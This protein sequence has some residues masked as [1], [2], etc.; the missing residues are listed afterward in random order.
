M[1]DP[2]VELAVFEELGQGHGMVGRREHDDAPEPG[3][4]ALAQGVADDDVAQRV[5]D[6]VVAGGAHVLLE[7]GREG[8][9]EFVE[10]G[11]FLAVGEV[12]RLVAGALEALG[13]D[14]HRGA[15]AAHA[16]QEDDGLPLLGRSW[17]GAGAEHER[18]EEDVG[19]C[20][21]GTSRVP[22]RQIVSLQSA[23]GKP[24]IP[25]NREIV[26]TRYQKVKR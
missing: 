26:K 5:G 22:P 12:Q 11:A 14:G 8:I 25:P 7:E 23:L 6:E 21:H 19:S 16:V 18:R 15:G 4:E 24:R 3:L 17:E 2:L 9:G 10:R 1:C 20:S 13:E